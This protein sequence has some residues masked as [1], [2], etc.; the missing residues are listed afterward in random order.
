[1]KHALA[2]ALP[3]VRQKGAAVPPVPTKYEGLVANRLRWPTNSNA[4]NKQLMSRSLHVASTDLTSLKVMWGGYMAGLSGQETGFDAA[5]DSYFDIEA[6][7]EYPAGNFTRLTFSGAA[8]APGGDPNVGRCVMAGTGGTLGGVNYN[9]F[10][11]YAAKVIP[12]GADF[13]INYWTNSPRGILYNATGRWTG[14]GGNDLCGLGATTPNRVMGGSITHGAGAAGCA[15]P[16]AIIGMTDAASVVLVGDSIMFGQGYTDVSQ[17]FKAGIIAP[18]IPASIPHVNMGLP[19]AAPSDWYGKVK[20]MRALFAYCSHMVNNLGINNITNAA[21]LNSDIAALFPA[22]VKKYLCTVTPRGQSTDGWATEE[23]QSS[24]YKAANQP[25]NALVRAGVAGY[26]AYIETCRGWMEGH[27]LDAYIWRVDE[28][29]GKFTSDGLHP[30]TVA[31]DWGR[32]NGKVAT[33]LW[34]YP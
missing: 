3:A 21:A 23:N 11:D 9:I 26:D 25:Y 13:W 6:S 20:N 16:A 8:Q 32:D 30:N 1:M 15:G 27:T 4:G 5:G 12:A 28:V 7:V 31:D 33:S 34:S 14:A 18:S 22:R 10:S 29:V 17:L 24:S 19:G 2:L